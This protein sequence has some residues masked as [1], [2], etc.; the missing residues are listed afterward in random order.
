MTPS[1]QGNERKPMNVRNIASLALLI[2]LAPS[3]ASAVNTRP[4]RLELPALA[5]PATPRSMT[6]PARMQRPAFAPRAAERQSRVAPLFR[7]NG[8]R[9]ETETR[10]QSLGRQALESVLDPASPA[11]DES[12]AEGQLQLKF[13]KQGNAF[14]D[15]HRTYREMCDRVSSKIWDDP[16]GKRVRFDVAGKPGLGVEIPIGKRR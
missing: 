14:R 9:V 15:L 4:L 7:R 3:Q 13:Q 16:N 1:P 5:A 2:G 10:A 8:G 11:L 12:R 6:A